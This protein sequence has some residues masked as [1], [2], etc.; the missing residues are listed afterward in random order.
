[1]K[2]KRPRTPT[3]DAGPPAKRSMRESTRICTL[4]SNN[5]FGVA[6][7]SIPTHI[8]TI[9]ADAT[10][11]TVVDSHSRSK[12]RHPSEHA[13]SDNDIGSTSG[14][15]SGSDG[16]GSSSS[17]DVVVQDSAGVSVSSMSHSDG[18]SKHRY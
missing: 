12:H 2:E 7:R 14:G 5:A 17:M 15:R 8:H 10:Q 13:I 3:S 11:D 16:G 18:R 4:A 1:M 6:A 9:D